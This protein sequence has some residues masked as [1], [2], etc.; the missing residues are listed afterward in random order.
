MSNFLLIEDFIGL[1]GIS[2]EQ[3][4]GLVSEEIA[5]FGSDSEQGAI[6]EQMKT[7]E[8]ILRLS[9]FAHEYRLAGF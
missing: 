9:E 5:A 7:G 4:F 3:I 2:L 8:H 1:A 6:V